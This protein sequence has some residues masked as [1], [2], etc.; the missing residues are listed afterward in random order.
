MKRKRYTNEQTA[1]ALR[2]FITFPRPRMPARRT[3]PIL[4]SCGAW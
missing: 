2:R 4:I 3:R 1:F